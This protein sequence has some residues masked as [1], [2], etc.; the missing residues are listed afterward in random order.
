M[1]RRR[2][3]SSRPFPAALFQAAY[4]EE[5]SDVWYVYVI[6]SLIVPPGK[7]AGYT[8]VGATN[9]PVRRLKQHNGLLPG[10]ARF[11]SRYPPWVPRALFGPYEGKRDALKAE[12]A[13]K[14][15]KRGDNRAKW[16]P[17]D[18]KWCCGLGP[19][20]PWVSDPTS[21]TPKPPAVP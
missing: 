12:Y 16:S 2:R 7:K 19:N 13:L 8:Y 5:T 3:R 10:G 21:L 6:Q 11:T 14:H 9:N 17:E 4:T 15:G 1:K 20:H 18:S